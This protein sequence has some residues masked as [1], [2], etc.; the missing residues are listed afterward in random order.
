MTGA[1]LL[2][3][4][5]LLL[6][7]V[8]T[9]EGDDR[10]PPV[11]PLWPITGGAFNAAGNY[12][13]VKGG[14]WVE[15]CTAPHEVSRDKSEGVAESSRKFSCV[16]WPI[17]NLDEEKGYKKHLFLGSKPS[18]GLVADYNLHSGVLAKPSSVKDAKMGGDSDYKKETK[19]QK[20]GIL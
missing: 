2:A 4:L 8:T 11:S 17:S 16:N 14:R 20:S 3:A 13:P 12:N 15:P 1:A 19:Y 6:C 5:C 10:R 18:D 9:P 7:E